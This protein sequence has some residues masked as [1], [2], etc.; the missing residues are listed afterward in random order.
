METD[1]RARKDVAH[2]VQQ[3]G[4]TP[5]S[6]FGESSELR[7]KGIVNPALTLHVRMDV[8]KRPRE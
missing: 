4:M 8:V 6:A 1:K 7:F 5:D 2:V 3:I